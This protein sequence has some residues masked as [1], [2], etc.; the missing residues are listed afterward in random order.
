MSIEHRGWTLRLSSLAWSVLWLA[1]EPGL[2]TTIGA[3]LA[4]THGGVVVSVRDATEAKARLDT[5]AINV[6]VIDALAM[7]STDCCV[8]L[9]LELRASC[10]APVLMIA[11]SIDADEALQYLRAGACGVM[12]RAHA[13]SQLSHAVVDA[14]QRRAPLSADIASS[15]LPMLMHGRAPSQDEV[16]LTDREHTILGMLVYG[17]AYAA[18]ATA[19]GIGLGTVQSHVKNLYRKLD[20]CTKAEAATVAIEQGLLRARPERRRARVT[21]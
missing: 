9:V 10:A 7:D 11:R 13:V 1:R 19:L 17:H 14:L 12:S 8:A 21:S 3:E 18:I 5:G 4:R 20:V 6:I 16:C 2:A 15:L